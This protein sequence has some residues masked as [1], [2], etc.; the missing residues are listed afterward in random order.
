[1]NEK[2]IEWSHIPFPYLG[3]PALNAVT[4]LFHTE[5]SDERQY[6]KILCNKIQ[7]SGGE[8][9]GGYDQNAPYDIF[10]E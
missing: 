5:I 4:C 10:E 9:V 1:M 8:V 6:M 2:S 7:M 3:S